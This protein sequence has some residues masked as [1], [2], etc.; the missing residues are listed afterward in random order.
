M[1]VLV[2]AGSTEAYALTEALVQNGVDVVAS[3]AG[4]TTSPREYPCP[5]R[6]G[7]FG[8]VDGLVNELRARHVHAL[9]DATHP[10]TDQMPAEA[11]AAAADAGVPHVRLVRPPWEPPAYWTEW[12]DADDEAAAAQ[13]LRDL[14]CTRVFLALGRQ[15]LDRFRDLDGIHLVVRC[16]DEPPDGPWAAV[17]RGRGPFSFA[18]ELDVLQRH[19]IDTVVTRNRGGPTAKLDAAR[20]AGARLVVIRRP[21]PVDAPTVYDIDAAVD[22]VLSLER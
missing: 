5:V 3:L 6:V 18:D 1:T 15:E 16:V 17:V 21:P 7:G 12:T 10:Y 11:R 9:V 20:A 2:L 4:R 13:A 14:D 19:R 22:W 8:G